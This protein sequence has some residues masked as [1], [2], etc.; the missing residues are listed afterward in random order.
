MSERKSFV[1]SDEDSARLER[2]KAQLRGATGS[3]VVMIAL[4][5]LDDEA[6]HRAADGQIEFHAR[7]GTIRTYDP[8]LGTSE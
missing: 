1:F 3:W 8:L 4:K 2:L 5:V 6:S 7:D